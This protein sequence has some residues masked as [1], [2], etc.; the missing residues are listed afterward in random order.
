MRIAITSYY[1]R[2]ILDKGLV[3]GWIKYLQWRKGHTVKGVII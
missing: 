1:K 2:G 3:C